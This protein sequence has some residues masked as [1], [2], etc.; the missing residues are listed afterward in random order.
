MRGWLLIGLAASPTASGVARPPELTINPGA[1]FPTT[2]NGAP[3]RLRVDP[4][5]AGMPVATAGLAGLAGL[6]AGPF[7]IEYII[8]PV[9]LEG[10]TALGRIDLGRGPELRRIAWFDRRWDPTADAVVGPGGVPA[11][12]VR[13]RL[14]PAR[15]GERVAALPMVG[16]GGLEDRWGGRFALVE[17]DGHPLR[18]RFDLDRRTTATASVGMMLAR[19]H[20]GS[21]EA[22]AFPAEIGLGVERPMRAFRLERP[23]PVGPLSIDRLLVR[24]ADHGNAAG[25]G[26]APPSR[27]PDEVVVT[28]RRK[29][30]RSRDHIVLGRDQL[31]R[32]SS[33]TFDKPAKQVRLSCL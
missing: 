16:Q 20:G 33:I 13:F 9:S 19:L 32:C 14:R 7:G 25:L 31:S 22:P 27:D 28:G 29:R 21:A 11:P 1:T 4:S 18:I 24:V 23:F 30:D 17:L 3:A 15:P 2:I 12:V 26:A 6:K 10:R 5:G 8:G